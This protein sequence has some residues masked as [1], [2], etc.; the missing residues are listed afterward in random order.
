MIALI[1]DVHGN[2]PALSAVLTELD[3]LGIKQ[4]V[5]LGDTAGY[6]PQINECCN[7]LKERS[8]T[9]VRGNHDHY[10][11]TG[12]PSGRSMTADMCIRYQA[13][14][15]TDENLKW[16][17]N[18]PRRL[19]TQ[20]LNLVHGGWAD[21]L[22]EYLYGVGPTTFAGQEGTYFASGHTHIPL[23]WEGNGKKYC[24]PGSV[25][26]P[27]DGDPRASFAIFNGRGFSLR[28][29]EYDIDAT[30]AAIGESGLPDYV[31]A[32]LPLGL[33]PGSHRGPG[34]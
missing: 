23:L 31:G 15:V 22:E 30:Q 7:A 28:R 24:N 12:A 18:L 1:S 33:P 16:L 10:L 9:G 6:G 20:G 27:R 4:I 29:V 25:G 26:Q 13:S 5:C 32:S 34:L 14:V 17:G 19:Q 8:V 21:P 2:L 3:Q 11:L